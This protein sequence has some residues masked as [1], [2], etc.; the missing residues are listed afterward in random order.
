MFRKIQNCVLRW[1]LIGGDRIRFSPISRWLLFRYRAFHSSIGNPRTSRELA[2][3]VQNLCSAARLAQNFKQLKSVEE[4]IHATGTTQIKPTELLEGTASNEIQKGLI[5]KPFLPDTQ[6]RGA[7]FISF[8]DQWARLLTL[9]SDQL[10]KFSKRYQLIVS[11]TWSP[12]HGLINC[13]FPRFYPDHIYCLISNEADLETIPRLSDK[14]RM[15]NLLASNW[16]KADAFAPKAFASRDIDL[17]MLANFGLFKRHHILFRAFRDLPQ[18]WRVLLIGQP[19]R[20]RTSKT[21]LREAESFGAL[22]RF[23]LRERIPHKDV[24][25]LLCRSKASVICSRREGSCVAVVESLFANTPVGLVESAQIGSAR[26]INSKTGVFLRESH[27]SED[28]KAFHRNAG[29][30]SAREWCLENGISAKESSEKLNTLLKEDA[31]RDGRPWTQDILPFH[32]C[33]NPYPSEDPPPA[34]LDGEKALIEREFG[35]RLTWSL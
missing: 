2:S 28:L 20:D 30:F 16:V 25:E 5:L 13:L 24:A 29:H 32:W 23:E 11:P 4:K 9:T 22:D 18:E 12:P 3:R 10:L 17:I 8:E 31:L 7:I 6:E 26:F 35:I 19:E 15:V 34:W 21:L 27:F 14:Y 1:K 33:P